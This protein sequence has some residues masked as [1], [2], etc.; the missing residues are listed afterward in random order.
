MI[1][2]ED[3]PGCSPDMASVEFVDLRRRSVV[4]RAGC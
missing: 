3:E 2:E 4:V 1:T